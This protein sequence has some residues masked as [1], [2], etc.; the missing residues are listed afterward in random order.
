MNSP[1]K[2]NE[3][4]QLILQAEPNNSYDTQKRNMNP[5]GDEAKSAGKS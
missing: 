3:G 2:V 4:D 5:Q 1:A